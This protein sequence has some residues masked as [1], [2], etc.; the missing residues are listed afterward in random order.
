M[1]Q[2]LVVLG[3]VGVLTSVAVF[4][5]RSA[6]SAMRLQSSAR[7][8]AQACERARLDAIRRRTTTHVEFT[9]SDKYEITMDFTG[10]GTATTR[11]FTLDSGVVVTDASGNALTSASEDLPYTDF[12]WRGRTYDCN[13]L[14]RLKNDRSDQ[15]VVQVAGSGDISVNT[16]VTSLPTVTYASVNSTVDVNPSATLAGNDNKLNLS[17]CGTTSVVPGGSGGGGGPCTTCTQQCVAGSITTSTAYISDLKRNG[18]NTR[19]VTVTVTGPG[20]ITVSP[21]ASLSVSPSAAQTITASSGGAV[22]YTIRSVTKS[23]SYFTVRFSYSNCTTSVTVRV[24]K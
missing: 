7:A 16:S 8:F 2:M 21:D 12:D 15:M 20:T 9:D 23:T 17:P 19:T 14:F 3:I 24:T 5:I 18:G 6:R 22:T 1:L 13:A 4:G 10:S 11:S